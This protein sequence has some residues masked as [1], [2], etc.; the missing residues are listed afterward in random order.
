MNL[1]S[2]FRSYDCVRLLLDTGADVNHKDRFES[3]FKFTFCLTVG[4][5]ILD[6]QILDH[7]NTWL[8][9]FWYSNGNESYVWS[10]HLNIRL[11][12]RFNFKKRD[13]LPYFGLFCPKLFVQFSDPIWNLTHF[14]CLDPHFDW[15]PNVQCFEWFQ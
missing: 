10:H 14:L 3:F 2:L 8:L 5:Q 9:P 1:I 4:I 12:L 15:P 7:R 13:I 6:A 11:V